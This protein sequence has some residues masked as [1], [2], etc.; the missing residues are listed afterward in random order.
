MGKHCWNVCKLCPCLATEST[1]SA[2]MRIIVTVALQRQYS[3]TEL[4]FWITL[5]SIYTHCHEHNNCCVDGCVCVS[6][7]VYI[8]TRSVRKVS[9][10]IFL[11]EHLME[12]N[13]A[14]LHEPTLNLSAH[15]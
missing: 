10:R 4:I 9:D 2:P 11:C 13:L 5:V 8:Y 6:V 1:N 12:Y 14:R 3:Q 15:A 7:C